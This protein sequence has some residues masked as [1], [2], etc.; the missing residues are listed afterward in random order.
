[1]GMKQELE[2][3]KKRVEELERRPVWVQP[4]YVPVPVPYPQPP[5]L[6]PAPNPW[7]VPHGPVWLSNTGGCAQTTALGTT[8]VTTN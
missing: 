7:D 2:E 8:L 5:P 4:Y 6:F 1:M 3:L